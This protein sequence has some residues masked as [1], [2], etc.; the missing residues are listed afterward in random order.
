M[1]PPP[2]PTSP[3]TVKDLILRANAATLL[4]SRLTTRLTAHP[5][6]KSLRSLR[7]EIDDAAAAVN[8]LRDDFT[9]LQENGGFPEELDELRMECE[10]AVIAVKEGVQTLGEMESAAWKELG[11]VDEWWLRGRERGR[12]A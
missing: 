1:L 9:G 6:A 8:T 10:I 4:H 3:D 5:T 12:G 7:L 11:K 2:P